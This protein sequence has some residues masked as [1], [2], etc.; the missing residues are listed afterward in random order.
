MVTPP[1]YLAGRLL[2]AMPGMGDPRFARAVIAMCVH[3][4]HGAMGIGIGQAR[5]G[6]SFHEI[7]DELDIAPGAAPDCPVMHGGPVETGRGFVLHSTDWGGADTIHVNPL[8]ALSASLG[9]LHA[10]ASGRGPSQWIVALGYT[11]WA[12]GQIEAEMQGHGWHA[13]SGRRE[14]LFDTPT[15]HRWTATWQA[16]GIDPALLASET[17]RA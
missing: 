10:I 5:P 16:E 2:L 14:I 1:Q 8:C 7:L 6:I 4:E 17:G 3:D 13:A 11:G 15:E 9:I 12:A